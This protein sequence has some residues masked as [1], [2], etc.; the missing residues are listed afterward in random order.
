MIRV[1]EIAG[2]TTIGPHFRLK[3]AKSPHGADFSLN[4][5]TVRVAETRD[6]TRCMGLIYTVSTGQSSESR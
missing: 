4:R 5:S 2:K 1:T 3:N 6:L